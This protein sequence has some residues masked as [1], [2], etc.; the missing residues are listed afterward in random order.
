MIQM[1]HALKLWLIRHNKDKKY[2]EIRETNIGQYFKEFNDNFD[3]LLTFS[4]I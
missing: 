3:L 1:I 2:K 4:L